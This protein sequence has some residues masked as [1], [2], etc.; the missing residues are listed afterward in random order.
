MSRRQVDITCQE[1]D[2]AEIFTKDQ[3]DLL[4]EYV[5]KQA[6]EDG[7]QVVTPTASKTS[8]YFECK[9]SGKPRPSESSGKRSKPSLK[10]GKSFFFLQ[11]ID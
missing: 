8:L 1:E 4:K 9:R 5:K 2:Y 7:F 10:I 3:V 11:L 6:I